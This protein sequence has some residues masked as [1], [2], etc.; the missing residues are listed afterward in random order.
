MSKFLTPCLR[1]G[2]PNQQLDGRPLVPSSGRQLSCSGVYFLTPQAPKNTKTTAQQASVSS[3]GHQTSCLGSL[4]RL[5]RGYP[6][7]S[8]SPTKWSPPNIRQ[9]AGSTRPPIF[10]GN[11]HQPNSSRTGPCSAQTKRPRPPTTPWRPPQRLLRAGQD[12][13]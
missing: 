6:P 12:Q 11:G 8:S 4:P 5:W 9:L 13:T 3:S 7:F 10:I 2:Q 1:L